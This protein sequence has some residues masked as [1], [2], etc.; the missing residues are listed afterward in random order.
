VIALAQGD[1]LV[2]ALIEG[3]DDPTMLVRGRV[4]GGGV[5]TKTRNLGLII[6]DEFLSVKTSQQI[7]T[8]INQ[9]FH[10]YDGGIKRGV[11][12][13]MRDDFVE[14]VVHPRYEQNLLRYVRVIQSIPVRESSG[15]VA[16]RRNQIRDDLM[17]VQTSSRAA[18]QLEA[19]GADGVDVLLDGLKSNDAEIRFYA[20]EALAYLDDARAVGVLADTTVKENAFRWRALTAL[21]AMEHTK[22]HQALEELLHVNSAE[23]RYGAFRALRQQMPDDPVVAGEFLGNQ[24]FYHKVATVGEPMVHVSREERPEIVIFG[25][26]LPLSQPVVLFAGNQIVAKS[27]PNGQIKVTRLAPG[28]EEEVVYCPHHVDALVRAI[29]ELG[30]TF[31][32]VVQALSNAKSHG[33][34]ACRLE[35]SALPRPGRT[36]HRQEDDGA[37]ILD[38]VD[39]SDEM[40]G[41]DDE[42]LTDEA[43]SLAGP[44]ASR[45]SRREWPAQD[46]AATDGTGQP[47]GTDASDFEVSAESFGVQPLVPVP[48]AAAGRQPAREAGRGA[49]DANLDALDALEFDAELR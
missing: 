3:S 25:Q 36:Y 19:L 5:S 42:V 11:A 41:S 4:L 48:R 14:L 46:E 15:G 29:V 2:D 17:S 18:L 6:R 23:A 39:D 44:G 34:L 9:R 7:G 45:G 13:P 32:D 40:V 16:G 47:A 24:F 26:E 1:V 31:P 33:S 22:A 21:Q 38:V 20:S 43:Q 35:F 12:K 8:A 49:E 28:D 37:P 27:Q 30:G 10:I